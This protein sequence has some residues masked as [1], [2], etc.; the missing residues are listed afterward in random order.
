M[1]ELIGKQLGLYQIIS[2]VGAGG[3]TVV[4]K[5][6]QANLDRYVAL[7][8]LSPQYID[9][10]IILERFI[11]EV[12]IVTRLEHP[13][14]LPTYDYGQEDSYFYIV[15]RLIESGSL[16]DR[17]HGQPFALSE[18]RK[19]I[20]QIGDALDYAHSQ[21]I[22]HRDIKMKNI[23]MDGRD[24]ALLTDFGI[25]KVLQRDA[26]LTQVGRTLGTPTYMAPEQIQGDPVDGRTDIYALGVLLYQLAT[27][28]F[29][30]LADSSPE[31]T[32]MHLY[33]PVPS[34]RAANPKL[35][36]ALD[37]VIATAMAKSP[38]DRFATAGE[39]VRAVQDATFSTLSDEELNATL[40]S[41]PVRSAAPTETTEKTIH[42]PITQITELSRPADLPVSKANP[43]MSRPPQ[44]RRNLP[45]IIG[46]AI[47]VFLFAI[48]GLGLYLV[49]QFMGQASSAPPAVATS[50]AG[51][52]IVW[53]E[54]IDQPELIDVDE[55]NESSGV[56]F[57][58][59]Y[60]NF[61]LQAEMTQLEG[62]AESSYGV[63]LRENEQGDSYY[64]FEI[65]QDGF[66]GFY[67]V[68]NCPEEALECDVV[69][70][71]AGESNA[72]RQEGPQALQV[73]AI[74]P[75]FTFYLNDEKIE[76]VADPAFTKGYTGLIVTAGEEGGAEVRF[77]R[78]KI[79]VIK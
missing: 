49:P 74:G 77:E 57:E 68:S 27:G 37:K 7:K 42:L 18:L 69:L 47:L 26:N 56:V 55:A 34:A 8:V 45:L 29:P 46:G 1:Q 30:Y 5:A 6:Y 40:P 54:L 67:K 17:F 48:T 72:I 78:L 51:T 13:H 76:G 12:Q 59:I 36:E 64:I 24:N 23:L 43:A 16:Y 63:T 60:Q 44:R 41:L 33:N 10:P 61:V 35:P 2:K 15:M 25:A 58:D 21:G 19:V 79:G 3:M 11:Q 71:R 28:R 32:M 65:S 66:W 53:E 20:S 39:M 73:E 75:D 31:I 50:P 38:N 14:I 62:S 52:N 22:V 70:I 4:Y 9:Q